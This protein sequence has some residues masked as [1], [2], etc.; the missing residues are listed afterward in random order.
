[1]AS[2]SLSG[3]VAALLPLA[4]AGAIGKSE[5]DRRREA[6][7]I[8]A[9]VDLAPTA[10]NMVSASAAAVTNDESGVGGGPDALDSFGDKAQLV[11]TPSGNDEALKSLSAQ[12]DAATQRGSA[13][14]VGAYAPWARYA[15][16][17]Q[18]RF[19][20]GEAVT[21][22]VLVPRV[23]LS[24]PQSVDCEDN[25][26]AVVIDIDSGSPKP[27]AGGVMATL[28]NTAILAEQLD[29]LRAAEIT[30]IWLSGRDASDAEAMQ[31]ELRGHGL[32]PS[33]A[34]DYL[35]LN[36]GP[37]DRKQIRRWETAGLFCILA[38]A[39][40]SRGDFDELYDYLL[41]PEYAFTL[42]RKFGAGWFTLP[43]PKTVAADAP[44]PVATAPETPPYSQDQEEN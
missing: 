13:F 11:D 2:L 16:D 6:G 42:E 8:A 23:S 9:G 25:P 1:M 34:G 21:S 30:I 22:A 29:A 44:S 37:D 19:Q 4:A 15:L 43:P 27:N 26:S 14:T 35:S 39:G 28:D 17:T 24:S 36:R 20:A 31:S 33:G 40:D 12:Y 7:L 32:L 38:V 10:P 5:I 3:C 41:K 18:N